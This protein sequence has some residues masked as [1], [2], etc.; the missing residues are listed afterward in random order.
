[1]QE[2]LR[3]LFEQIEEHPLTLGSW[4]LT[5]LAIIIGRIWI[6]NTFESLQFAFA[7]QFFYQFSHHLFTFTTIFLATLPI[8][9]WAG[10]IELRKAANLLLVG[11]LLIWTPPIIDEIISHGAGLWS[12]YAFDSLTGLVQR[13]FT[14]FGDRPDIGVTYGPRIDTALSIIFLTLYTYIKTRRVGRAAIAGWLIYTQTFLFAALPSIATFLLIGPN[15]GFLSVTEHDIA[16]LILAPAPLFGL[17]PPTIPSVIS[18]KM[19]L[20]YTTLIIPLIGVLVFTFFRT[21]FWALIHNARF[22]QL[23][24]H[25]GLFLVGAGLAS[26]YGESNW[27]PNFF[28]FAGVLALITA[29]SCAWLASVVVNDLRDVAIDRI[30]NT[31]RPLVTGAITVPTYKTIGILLFAVSI[32][33]AGLVSTQAALLLVLYQA[34]AFLYSADPLRL[35]RIPLIATAIAAMASL[36]ILFA[37]FIV[38]STEK[39][40]STLPVSIPILLFFAYLA[41][42]PIKDFKDIVGDAADG[43]R[44]LPVIL[45]EGRAKRFIGAA[46]FLVFVVSPFVLSIRSLFPLGL[47][48]GTLGYWLLQLASMDHRYLSY[49]KL[50]GWFMLLAAGY[51]TFLALALGK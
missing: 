3:K 2:R 20:I 48:F 15:I 24:Y 17:D 9:A 37:G 23:L 46:V 32:F 10:K 4:A 26:L 44:T 18:I 50:P 14:F 43:V 40:I 36:L 45:G 12:F 30:T 13:Y 35:K 39:N 25:T 6:E 38:F 51:G 11:F 8:V 22:P 34:L 49:R 28:H 33:L 19:S 1:M 42:I 7:D 47:F 41:I 27:I 29:V 31:H 5:L 16:L 21:T